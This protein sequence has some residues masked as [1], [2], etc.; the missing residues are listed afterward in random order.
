MK[1]ISRILMVVLCLALL[2]SS[3][4]AYTLS[5]NGVMPVADEKIEL[6]VWTAVDHANVE[7]FD[8]N[9][10]TDRMEALTNVHVVW[11]QIDMTEKETKFNL[12][13]TRDVYPDIFGTGFSTDQ[14]MAYGGKVLIPLE[15][16][17]DEYAPNITR[18]L[19]SDPVL[20][21]MITAPDGHIYTLF[22]TDNGT[23]QFCPTKCFVRRSWLNTYMEDGNDYPVTYEDFENM[24]QYFMD[25]DMN[26]NGDT[27][28][29]IPFST[30]YSF[31]CGRPDVYLLNAFQMLG[32][33]N[34]AFDYITVDADGNAYNGAIT[35]ECREGLKW[36]NGM[37]EKGLIDEATFVQTDA[38]AKSL[39]SR[40]EEEALVGCFT[41][42]YESYAIDT[43]VCPNGTYVALAPIEG[44]TGL[45]QA[46]V[47]G[48]NGISSMS[49]QCAITVSCKDPVAAIKWL[50]YFY[51]E[52]P[53]NIVYDGIQ[54]E[55]FI[56]DMEQINLK[57]EAGVKVWTDEYKALKEQLGSANMGW[58]PHFKPYYATTQN[59]FN[60][61]EPEEGTWS[62]VVN[63][64]HQIYAPFYT[65][66]GYPMITWSVNAEEATECAEL[67]AVF[68]SYCRESFTKFITGVWD[69]DSDE[70]WGAYLNDMEETYQNSR[71]VELRQ[72]KMDKQ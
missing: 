63:E 24:L 23:N 26:G 19:D 10:L 36:I 12:A 9:L 59:S 52:Y 49:L 44:P 35:D 60:G 31:W 15:D 56:I 51:T 50:D 45:R 13:L 17:I 39:I 62:Y 68:R 55:D 43:A 54:G 16:L 27:A 64:A 69:I 3:A 72:K 25:N 66:N 34:N 71:W 20:K 2:S 53:N 18:I 48:S 33:F 61:A 37:Y 30:S 47:Y 67:E 40:S 1:M 8:K 58:G 5:D 42:A 6:T 21:E 22:S 11:E 4:L 65:Y 41:S 32:A 57:G 7:D 70:D 46:P 29:E 14:I 28:D 38:Q